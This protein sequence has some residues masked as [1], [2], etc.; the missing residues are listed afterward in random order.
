VGIAWPLI[1]NS[2]GI[3]MA[4]IKTYEHKKLPYYKYFHFFSAKNK[5]TI[6]VLIINEKHA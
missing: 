2:E 5:I 6:E 1:L 4:A 3:S